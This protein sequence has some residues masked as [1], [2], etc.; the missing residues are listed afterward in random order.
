MTGKLWRTVYCKSREERRAEA[1]LEN[2]GFE[3][4]LP[5]VRT[6]T[7]IRGRTQTRVEPMFP[8]YLFI[9]LE[10]FIDDWSTIRST[11]GVISLVRFGDQFP[12]I[13]DGLVQALRTQ[14]DRKGVVDISEAMEIRPDDS[15]EITDGALA[16]LRAIFR[17]R[18][19]QERVTVLLKMLN[20]EKEIELPGNAIRKVV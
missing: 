18:S 17:A 11:R 19:G 13:Q 7:R 10:E 12:T 1:H 15:V 6:L 4:F 2:Q 5:R 9:A 3:V 14:H 16:G 20:H 8:R